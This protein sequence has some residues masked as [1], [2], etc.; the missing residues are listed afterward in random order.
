M[1]FKEVK[2]DCHHF[3]TTIPCSPNKKEGVTCLDCNFYKPITKRILIIKL[4][5]LGDVIRTTPLV[6]KYK[7][8][9]PSAHFTWITQSPAVLPSDDIQQILK[10]DATSIYIIENSKYDI[11]INL[12]KEQEACTLLKNVDAKKKYGYTWGDY[13]IAPATPAAEH[14]LMTGFFDSISVE[15]KKSY[16]EEIFEI[17][18][19]NFDKE[20]YLINKNQQ[21]ADFWL[22]KWT[23]L[24]EGREIV[25]LNTGCGPRW[26]TRLWTNEEWIAL[27]EKLMKEGYYPV[28]LGGELEH[29]KNEM[30]AQETGAHYP[31]Y[32][33][34]E[35]FIAL[36]DGCQYIVTQVS[37]MMHIA[38]AL[39]KKMVLMNNIFNKYEFE[40]Y[41]RGVIVE[42]KSGCICY[43]GNTCKKGENSCM[44][45]ITHLDIFEAIQKL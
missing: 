18:H 25:G 44:H 14:K 41:D 21:L 26:N 28:F 34:L 20:P 37:M 5:A 17:C 4:G 39:Q 45:E 33:S 12:D 11:A 3:R 24:A 7:E 35:E 9:Y 43:F 32:F 2:T 1:N 36:A 15:N 27:A 8:L 40:L 6:V 10:W 29:E 38:T 31:G 23:R 42:P 13:A 30:F 16:L 22:D 19:F